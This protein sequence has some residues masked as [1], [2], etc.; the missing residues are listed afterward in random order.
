[1][2][3]LNVIAFDDPMRAQELLLAMTRLAKAGDLQL[4]DAVFVTRTEEGRVKVHETSDLTPG[5]GA[6]SGGFWGLLFGTLLL[7]PLGGLAVGA[8]SAGT[9]ALMGKLIDAGVHDDFVRQIKAE[10]EPGRTA[11]IL[12]TEGGDPA[13]V[14]AELERFAGARLLW[15]NLPPG[16]RREVEAALDAG[17]V[18][19][20]V[21]V[22][23]E[24]PADG[25]GA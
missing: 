15:S 13:K 10:V 12:L 25:A 1:M 3:Q 17:H 6:L 16:A 7:G 5:E 19:H 22:T 9:G 11:L 21:D 8:A 18:H 20:Q 14:E 2:Q 4:E 23:D 24:H